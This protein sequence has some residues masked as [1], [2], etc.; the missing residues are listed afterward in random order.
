MWKRILVLLLQLAVLQNIFSASNTEPA[1]K[2]KLV[3][4]G[5]GDINK[6]SGKTFIENIETYRAQNSNVEIVWDIKYGDEYEQELISTLESGRQLDIIY[7]ENDSLR[8]RIITQRGEDID[9]FQFINSDSF[10][11]NS[12]NRNYI[13]YGKYADTVIYSNNDLLNKLGL[14]PATTYQELVEQCTVAESSNKTGVLF[15]GKV[16]WAYTSLLYSMILGRFI[17]SDY[18][19]TN[20]ETTTAVLNF[21]NQMKEDGVLTSKLINLDYSDVIDEFNSGNALYLIDGPWRSEEI[22]ITN[23]GWNKFVSIPDELYSNTMNGGYTGG[24]AILKNSVDDPIR[25]G[26]SIK[27]LNYLLGKEASL[28]RALNIGVVPTLLIDEAVSYS[29]INLDKARYVESIGNLTPT[30]S[31][32]M[33]SENIEKLNRG[34]FEILS[35]DKTTEE[36]ILEITENQIEN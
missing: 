35:G 8:T 17:N 2:P 18:E 20:I 34:I 36:F 31:D 27:L 3:V 4:L 24:Y 32:Y 6:L 16:K 19:I 23:L 9:Q 14:N 11:I 25:K 29:S 15:P 22:K 30:L 28:L 13:P 33:I 5:Y 26:E 21:I 12:K 7:V 1:E 10:T